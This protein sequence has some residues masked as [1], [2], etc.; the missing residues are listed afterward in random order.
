M[1]ALLHHPTAN[2]LQTL[3]STQGLPFRP[4]FQVLWTLLGLFLSPFFSPTPQ[5]AG[6]GAL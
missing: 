2:R 3:S 5:G 4:R 1:P 6:R